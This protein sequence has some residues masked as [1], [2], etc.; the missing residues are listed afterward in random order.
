MIVHLNLEDPRWRDLNLE[1]LADQAARAALVHLQLD[2][3]ICEISLLA[4]NDAGITGLNAGF[5][6]KNRATNV[7]SW[8]T[9]DLGA[10]TDG[11]APRRPKAG[12]TGEMMLG[13][14]AIAWETCVQ[15]ARGEGRHLGDHVSH[16]L[17]HAVLH[18]L[19]YD[20]IRDL[21]ATLMMEKEVEILGKLGI[22][23]PY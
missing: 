12:F 10:Q 15:E 16:L 13:D 11:A 14:I 6:G 21:D 23:N 17:V 19:G 22:G 18:L 1:P 8:P 2:P 9:E 20:H 5:R 3:E 4:C 7:L